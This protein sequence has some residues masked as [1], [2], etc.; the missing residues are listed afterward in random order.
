MW[1]K[2]TAMYAI[3]LIMLIYSWPICTTSAGAGSK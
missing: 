1:Y 2:K 3:S